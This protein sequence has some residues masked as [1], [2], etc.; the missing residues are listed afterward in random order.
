VSHAICT[1]RVSGY[2]SGNSRAWARTAQS[3]FFAAACVAALSRIADILVN[4]RVNT[5]IEKSYMEID[6]DLSFVS[7]ASRGDTVTK[8]QPVE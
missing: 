6:I 7:L 3:N 4:P 8:V 5:G 1:W 2:M